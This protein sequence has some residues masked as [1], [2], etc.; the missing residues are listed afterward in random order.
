MNGC[1]GVTEMGVMRDV[2][3]AVDCNSRDFA[4]LG[5][6]SLTASGSSFQTALTLLLTLYVAII[7]YR[8]L[9]ARGGARLGD[10]PGIALKVGAILALVASWNLF[11]TLVFDLAERAPVEIAA[12]ISAPLRGDG[13][14]A[15]D[16][17]AG[18][19]ITYDRL[20][21]AAADFA[22]PNR[23]L[24]DAGQ[25]G[26]T[27]ASRTLSLSAVALFAASIGLISVITVAIGILTATGP[28]F[29]ALFLLFETRGF[30]V[31]WVRAL[32][33]CAFALLSAW[34]LT[35]LMLTV[36]R[37]WL[38][39][40]ATPPLKAQ[41]GLTASII[42]LV[43]AAAQI[44]LLLAA[45]MAARGFRL[46]RA[47]SSIAPSAAAADNPKPAAPEMVSRPARLAA[48]L[49]QQSERNTWIGRMPVMAAGPSRRDAV[50]AGDAAPRLG[51]LYRR[52][53]VRRPRR[54]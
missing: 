37:P 22:K 3:W 36:L 50:A 18:L 9:F 13:S 28:L 11:Q 53:A 4:R 20:T 27:T 54:Q 23:Q 40:L 25:A 21:E 7:G 2:L 12:A 49:Q 52:P 32:A 44:G 38:G 31:G 24:S 29:I 17:L 41:T 5:Y 8:L 46:S 35:V 30:F 34:T 45:I 14:L 19:E 15:A 1:S 39:A 16:P 10:A 43:F 33:A 48:H 26:L 47:P 6:E 42:V 51:D